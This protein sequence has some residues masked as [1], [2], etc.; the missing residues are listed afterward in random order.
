MHVVETY[1]APLQSLCQV[2]YGILTKTTLMTT[3]PVHLAGH[4]NSDV[5]AASCGA[6]TS[7]FVFECHLGTDVPSSAQKCP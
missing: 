3:D 6:W 2:P 1:A 4:C 5:I 7:Q